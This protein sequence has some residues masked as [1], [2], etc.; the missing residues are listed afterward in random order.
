M[1]PKV[2]VTKEE[3]ID[4]A[5]QIAADEGIDAVTVR[6]VAR[7]IGC[8]VAPIYVNFETSEDLI[9]AVF[10]RAEDI[11]FEYMNGD[12]S[13]SPFLNMGI[14]IIMFA[15]AYNHLFRDVLLKKSRFAPIEGFGDKKYIELMKRDQLVKGLDDD[16]LFNILFKLD[17]FTHG[18]ALLV[19]DE[20]N[21]DLLSEEKIISIL[22]ETG[23]DIILSAQLR[24]KGEYPHDECD[25]C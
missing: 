14:G 10:E 13:E 1:P 7:R 11:S 4:A 16:E 8:S 20:N 15:R 12:Y 3:L 22:R 24:K 23:Y 17:I 6:K 2:K 5:F 25:N 18:L 21:K 19:S 9:R